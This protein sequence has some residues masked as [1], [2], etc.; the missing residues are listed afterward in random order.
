MNMNKTEPKSMLEQS[1]VST[2][3]DPTSDKPIKPLSDSG[4]RRLLWA[5]TRCTRR[6][7]L[8][9]FMLGLPALV[10]LCVALKVIA[11]TRLPRPPSVPGLSQSVG[12]GMVPAGTNGIPATAPAPASGTSVNPMADFWNDWLQPIIGLFTLLVAIFVWSSELREEWEDNLPKL[13]SVYFFYQDSPVLVCRYAYLSAEG[14]IRPMAQQV[15]LQ[16]TSVKPLKF[17]P[18][19]EQKPPDLMQDIHRKAY[20][21]YRV[22]FNLTEMPDGLPVGT[23]SG[24]IDKGKLWTITGAS[25]TPTLLDVKDLLEEPDVK[26]W[27]GG[28]SVQPATRAIQT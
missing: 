4:R 19:I 2:R 23:T 7:Q 18:F 16:M 25:S 11:N 26:A 17:V 9:I 3:Q 5:F 15:G 12:Q 22:R 20:K 10:F 6:T 24:A 27:L 28:D 1:S 14:D 21:H 8:W 13:L